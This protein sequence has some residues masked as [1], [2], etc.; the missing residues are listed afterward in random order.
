MSPPTHK[1]RFLGQIS[2]HLMIIS[3]EPPTRGQDPFLRRR[4]SWR[5]KEQVGFYLP[6]LF[7]PSSFSSPVSG[8]AC[9][10]PTPAPAPNPP[11]QAA[12]PSSATR[13][14][15]VPHHCALPR[16]RASVPTMP[17]MPLLLA[18]LA[19]LVALVVAAHP[20]CSPGPDHSGRVPAVPLVRFRYPSF[21]PPGNFSLLVGR[22]TTTWVECPEGATL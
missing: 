12:G 14:P 16:I 21:H 6:F 10:N 20:S 18:A 1:S 8:A 7:L 3:P 17:T 9:C 4:G 13:A 19:V 15:R 11:P 22:R 5:V 2:K